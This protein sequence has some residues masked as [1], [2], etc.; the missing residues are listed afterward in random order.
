MTEPVI[1][2]VSY[3]NPASQKAAS[4]SLRVW[5]WLPSA[6]MPDLESARM[7]VEIIASSPSTIPLELFVWEQHTVFTEGTAEKKDRVVCVAKVSDLSVYPARAVDPNSTI[8]PFY[9][10]TFFDTT[11]SSPEDLASSWTFIIQDLRA[12]L[13]SIIE[14]SIIP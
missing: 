1:Y 12:L 5:K 14:L 9:R 2:E 11:F 8:P 4:L 10:D 6:E 3:F 13:K 7:R